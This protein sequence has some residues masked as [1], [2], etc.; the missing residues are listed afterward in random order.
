VGQ[1]SLS[2]NLKM[3]KCHVFWDSGSTTE[4]I[5]YCNSSHLFTDIMELLV[6]VKDLKPANKIIS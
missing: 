3:C 5:Q 6:D 1:I 2:L 4:V